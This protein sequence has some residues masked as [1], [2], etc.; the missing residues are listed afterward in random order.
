MAETLDFEEP[1]APLVKQLDDLILL[2]RT[3]SAQREIDA[4]RR[5]I[6]AAR[7]SPKS[8]FR[9]SWRRNPMIP[10][11]TVPTTSMIARR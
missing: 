3:D 5:K 7:G 11:G 1:I 2:P 4:L 6:D 9:G 10:V 8:D